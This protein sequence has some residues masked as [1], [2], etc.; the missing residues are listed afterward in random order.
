LPAVGPVSVAFGVEDSYPQITVGSKYLQLLGGA[1][2]GG[3][4]SPRG[5]QRTGLDSLQTRALLAAVVGFK[6][7]SCVWPLLCSVFCCPRICPLLPGLFLLPNWLHVSPSL[8]HGCLLAPILW[9]CVCFLSHL[10]DI[11]CWF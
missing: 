4:R 3:L 11:S 9:E 6:A 10:D 8:W 5:L 1:G 2:W 7:C